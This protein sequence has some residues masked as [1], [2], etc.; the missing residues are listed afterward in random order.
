MLVSVLVF[1]M[2]MGSAV[3]ASTDIGLKGVGA[4][5]GLFGPEGGIGSAIGFGGVVDLGWITPQIGLEADVL[6]W[7]K[8][9]NE[10][11]YSSTYD[12]KYSEFSINVMGKYYFEQK[13]G[14]KIKPYAGAGL[15]MAFWKVSW[16]HVPYWGDISSNGS[17]VTVN[18]VGGAKMV[19]SPKV[20]GFAEFR[21]SLGGW[22]FWGIF[23]GAIMSLK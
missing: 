22:D 12:V 15:G 23:V 20:D 13:K 17:D 19:L 16:P 5:V 14:S 10:G 9:Y 7:G 11:Y 4:K 18:A 8:S 1:C 6:Y 3:F 2:I 21:Y